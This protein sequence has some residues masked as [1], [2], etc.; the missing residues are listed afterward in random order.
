MNNKP[1]HLMTDKEKLELRIAQ[2]RAIDDRL[3]QRRKP[4][5]PPFRPLRSIKVGFIGKDPVGFSHAETFPA[6]ASVIKELCGPE[7]QFVGHRRIVAALIADDEVGWLLDQIVARDP[8]P[9]R[10]KEWW[11]NSMMSW[12]SQ[13]ITEQTNPFT[14]VFERHPTLRPYEYRLRHA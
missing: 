14:E 5:I 7:N 9:D 2:N 3:V 1:Y 10:D 4:P 12:F 13:T 11:A 8:V 6:I